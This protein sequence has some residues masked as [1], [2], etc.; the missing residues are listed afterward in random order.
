MEF[1]TLLFMPCVKSLGFVVKRSSPTSRLFLPK[2]EVKLFQYS[3]SS[4]LN[5]SSIDI[6]GNSLNKE[7]RYSIISQLDKILFSPFKLYF[8]FS[9]NSPA[10]TSKASLISSDEYPALFIASHKISKA[11]FALFNCGAKPPSSPTLVDKFFFFR[12]FFK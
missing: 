11:S 10:A 3:K 1:A 6:I 7:L 12:I 9:Y 4:A 5:P 2:S 8:P